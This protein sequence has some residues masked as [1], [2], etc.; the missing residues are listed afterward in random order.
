MFQVTIFSGVYMSVINK[1]RMLELIVEYVICEYINRNQMFTVYQIWH[2]SSFFGISGLNY[3]MVRT[4]VENNINDNYSKYPGWS[5]SIGNHLKKLDNSTGRVGHPPQIYHPVG[6]DIKKYDPDFRLCVVTYNRTGSVIA[7]SLPKKKTNNKGF[8]KF[9]VWLNGSL[10]SCN[11]TNPRGSGGK[12]L[13]NID[14]ESHGVLDN[15]QQVL[16][17]QDNEGKLYATIV[18]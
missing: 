14:G 8:C 16:I 1:S 11:L 12:F 9:N 6:A 4:I 15:G 13:S 18:N 3:D 5:R 17:R 2:D 10:V 7:S